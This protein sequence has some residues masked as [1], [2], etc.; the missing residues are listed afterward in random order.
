MI[1]YSQFSVLITDLSTRKSFDLA[2]ILTQKGINILL[3]DDLKGADQIM[4]ES[5][6]RKKC[7]L[8]R[9]D[10]NFSD[11]LSK[12]L[13]N[14]SDIKIVYFPIEEDTTLLVYNFLKQH[15]YSN[16]YHNLPLQKSFDTV[17]NKG[18]FS[19]FC[20]H[21]NLAVPKEYD[22]QTLL[23]MDDLPEELILKPK[24]GSGSVGIRFLDTKEDLLACQRLVI[25]DYIIQQ[26]LKNPKDVEGAFFLFD[27][28]KYISY[29]GHKRIRTFPPE[30]GVSIYSKC[31]CKP[32][33]EKLG[34]KLLEK[35][36]WSGLAMVEFL[37][38]PDT[39]S[40]KIIEV[41]PRLWGSLMLS[42]FCGSNMIE[43][44]CL[45]ALQKPLQDSCIQEDR[46]IRWFFP[47]ELLAYV[48]SR[49][50]IPNFW[51]FDTEHTCYINVS[52]TTYWHSFLF[53]LYNIVN[54]AKLKRLYQKVFA[55]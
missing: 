50:S 11:D 19:K 45:T 28:G 3:C 34:V 51:H 21:K 43:N 54:P 48:K 47:W 18:I 15:Q 37:Y 40:Y 16:F 9:K 46:Y 53:T 6:Y 26:R 4:L 44:Y 2:N 12:I 38:D 1:N 22:F 30:G 31:E 10:T 7:E 14:H 49:A 52:Y 23:N 42:E 24:N 33:L 36:E 41:N 25:D 8:L 55:R 29:Y 20:L 32:E 17:R 5:A 39:D 13:Q 35:L 27:K